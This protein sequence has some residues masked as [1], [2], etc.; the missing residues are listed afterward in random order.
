[1]FFQY[2][3]FQWQR[4]CEL[5]VNFT[6]SLQ[7]HFA[8]DISFLHGKRTAILNFT[9]VKMTEI[10]IKPKWIHITPVHVKW[11]LQQKWNFTPVW[12][13]FRSHV[14]VLLELS[15]VIMNDFHYNYI[16][17]KYRDKAKVFFNDTDSLILMYETETES[18]WTFLQR[19]NINWL[20]QIFKRFKI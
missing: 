13:H 6:E 17:N 15:K 11:V 18:V 7:L 14:N 19:Q 9:T 2:I 10:K 8:A 4:T 5:N 16:K 12:V 1:M 3:F 20:Q